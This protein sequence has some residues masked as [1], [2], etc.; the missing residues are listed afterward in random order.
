MR[1]T[2]NFDDTFTIAFVIV[3]DNII[4]NQMVKKF[5]CVKR[6]ID[7]IEILKPICHLFVF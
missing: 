1:G 4:L 5:T 7:R 3:I 2:L 6:Y